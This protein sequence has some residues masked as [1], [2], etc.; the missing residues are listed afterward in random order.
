MIIGEDEKAKQMH[1]AC[2]LKSLWAPWH[3]GWKGRWPWGSWDVDKI[4]SKRL[5]PESL[6]CQTWGSPARSCP[7]SSPASSSPAPPALCKTRRSSCLLNRR[8]RTCRE[9][10]QRPM[11]ARSHESRSLHLQ[12]ES[13]FKEVKLWLGVF[14]GKMISSSL[15]WSSSSSSWSTNRWECRSTGGWTPRSSTRS[16]RREATQPVVC[17]SYCH[18]I[19]IS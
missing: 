15:P 19:L 9:S 16:S 3:Q 2:T 18:N 12:A 17:V 13:L 6:Y 11:C 7:S 4:L 14:F 8:R 1:V 5:K 10:L